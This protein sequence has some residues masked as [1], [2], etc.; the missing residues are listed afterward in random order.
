MAK[1]VAGDVGAHEQTYG[2]FLRLLKF[3]TIASFLVAAI[4]VLIIGS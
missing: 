1:N 4:V 2:G 3:G